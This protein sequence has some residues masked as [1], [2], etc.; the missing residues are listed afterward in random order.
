MPCYS[1][2]FFLLIVLLSRG[3]Q[4]WNDFPWPRYYQEYYAILLVIFIVH[5]CIMAWRA[6]LRGCSISHEATAILVGED[7]CDASF[8]EEDIGEVKYRY[9]SLHFVAYLV[10]FVSSIA[11]NMLSGF[12]INVDDRYHY[13]RY[14]QF[15]RLEFD[16]RLGMHSPR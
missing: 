11:L 13:R 9:A 14:L 8:R 12:W 2:I 7:F 6:G 5:A 4:F 16:T 3:Q 10:L 1:K 15:L